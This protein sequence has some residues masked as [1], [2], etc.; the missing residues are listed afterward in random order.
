VSTAS[1]VSTPSSVAGNALVM[2]SVPDAARAAASPGSAH[3]TMP[4]PARI[5]A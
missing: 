2:T 3:H 5:A 4:A 1:P